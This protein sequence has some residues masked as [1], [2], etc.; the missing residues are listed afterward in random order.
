[1][2]N[3][4]TLPCFN[5]LCKYHD[6]EKIFPHNLM[7]WAHF[8]HKN[9][10]RCSRVFV[11]VVKWQK[12]AKKKTLVQLTWVII[13]CHQPLTYWSQKQR[14]QFEVPNDVWLRGQHTIRKDLEKGSW[15]RQKAS[16]SQSKS[17]SKQVA[18]WR[19]SL[20]SSSILLID[21][22][23]Q[24]RLHFEMSRFTW[25]FCFRFWTIYFPAEG[26]KSLREAVLEEIHV[27]PYSISWIH[28]QTSSQVWSL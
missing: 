25:L 19:S 4:A 20:A 22:H 9:P 26:G 27:A 13:L 3:L 10:L 7:T 18:K 23:T 14:E 12:I 28:N 6:F 2:Y 15:E 8:S 16:N 21:L 24:S 5:L 11:V 1:M 17:W